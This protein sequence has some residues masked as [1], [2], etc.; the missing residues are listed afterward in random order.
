MTKQEVESARVRE[1]ECLSPVVR[2]SHMPIHEY[3]ERFI[4]LERNT[5][6]SKRLFRTVTVQEIT[7]VV[8]ESVRMPS[9]ARSSF[10]QIIFRG[11]NDVAANAAFDAAEER[12]LSGDE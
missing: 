12:L 2:C 10:G 9:G 5:R 8:G 3:A 7:V 4:K 11:D 6:R 1:C